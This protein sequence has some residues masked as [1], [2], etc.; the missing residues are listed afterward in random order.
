MI[1]VALLS[2]WHVHADDYARQASENEHLSIKLVWDDDVKRGQEWAD[3][4]NVPFE[5]DLEKVLSSSEID[6]V[7][8]DTPTTQH[9]EVI[10][11]A[12]NHKKHIFTEKVL[13]LTV[14][15]CEEILDAV[16]ENGVQFMISLPRLTEN[17]YLY[18]QNIVDQGEIGKLT[19]I[20][21]DLLITVESHRKVRLL[22]G[23]QSGFITL[24]KQEEVRLSI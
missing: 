22:A 23:F 15:E 9:K 21:C 11:A 5:A 6:A 12:A 18:A 8:V 24:P 19:S 14:S 2:R 1:N 13:A 20:R 4:L 17:Y 10:I 7:I 3:S 16:E